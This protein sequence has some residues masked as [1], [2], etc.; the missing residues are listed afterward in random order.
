NY[1]EAAKNYKESIR[2]DPQNADAY[3]NLAWL[4]CTKK[5]NLD[6][7]EKLVLKAI[8]INP[9]KENIYIDTLDN[10]KALNR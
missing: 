10:I 6:E 3:N 1:K 2:K 8:K 9:S 5:E 4:Y 7:A